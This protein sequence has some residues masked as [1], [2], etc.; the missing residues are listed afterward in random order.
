MDWAVDYDRQEPY[1]KHRFRVAWDGA[2]IR[3]ISRVT[4]LA[5]HFMVPTTG[6]PAVPPEAGSPGSSFG[7]TASGTASPAQTGTPAPY[8]PVQFERGRTHDDSFEKWA[9]LAA[10]GPD[11][12]V[13]AAKTVDL[14]LLDEAGDI[15]LLF[16]LFACVPVHYV[17]LGPLD[18]N[19]D[20]IALESLT[21]TYERLERERPGTPPLVLDTVL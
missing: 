1:L 12:R 20:G 5:R 16:R 3:G 18:A 8:A 14:E 13:R 15:V 4:P 7:W 9:A 21:I 19:A 11:P 10:A 17:A 2:Y 6:N